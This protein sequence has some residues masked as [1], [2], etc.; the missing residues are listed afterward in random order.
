[1]DCSKRRSS[2]VQCPCSGSAAA[3]PL[4][5][6][7][8][9]LDALEAASAAGKGAEHIAQAVRELEFSKEHRGQGRTSSCVVDELERAFSQTSQ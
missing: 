3:T 7:C 8:E 5:G 2:S 1:M 4:A 9:G 6:G